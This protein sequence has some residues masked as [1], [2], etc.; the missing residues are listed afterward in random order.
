MTTNKIQQAIAN[1]KTS[2]KLGRREDSVALDFKELSFE[3]E[4]KAIL[5]LATNIALTLDKWDKEGSPP[6]REIA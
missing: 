3:E 6:E 5:I 4:L 1:A 2:V